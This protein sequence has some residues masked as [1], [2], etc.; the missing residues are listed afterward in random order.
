M[1]QQHRKTEKR[2]RRK[3]YQERVLERVREAKSKKKR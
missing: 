3:R 1:S 2:A